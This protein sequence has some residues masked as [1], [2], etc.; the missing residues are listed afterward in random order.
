MAAARRVRSVRDDDDED[1]DEC[2]D[3]DS[4]GDTRIS[5]VT[6]GETTGDFGESTLI[7][8]RL[9]HGWRGVRVE[10]L[11]ARHLDNRRV[12]LSHS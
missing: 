7:A 2:A 10:R 5:M 1:N 3:E 8:K 11:D 9:R 4:T 6:Y 12:C